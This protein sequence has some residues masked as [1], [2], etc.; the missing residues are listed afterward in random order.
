MAKEGRRCSSS[1]E[2]TPAPSLSDIFE[3]EI[4][5][6]ETRIDDTL[7]LYGL[8]VSSDI[9]P[10]ARWRGAFR[11]RRSYEVVFSFASVDYDFVE[12]IGTAPGIVEEYMSISSWSSCGR[13]ELR[14]GRVGT[15][16]A[17]HTLRLLKLAALF[18]HM[19]GGEASHLVNMYGYIEKV[20]D[21]VRL[22][23]NPRR[24]APADNRGLGGPFRG[25]VEFI[26]DGAS[27]NTSS[28]PSP[29]PSGWKSDEPG[30]SA[31]FEQNRLCRREY[32]HQ[33]R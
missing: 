15:A 9:I 29:R 6:R 24:D 10:S 12:Y 33:Q 4:G 5:D 26:R 14:R 13:R 32:C 21:T 16:P 1:H 23:R 31:S 17:G 27:V 25:I 3:K 20:K 2:R 22:S 30:P 7:E 28:S 11:G 8:E 19:G 18:W